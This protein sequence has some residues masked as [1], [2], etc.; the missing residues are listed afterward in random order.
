MEG[1]PGLAEVLSG[2][3]DLDT[4]LRTSGLPNLM[5]L[6][7]GSATLHPSRLLRS[8]ATADLLATLRER[9]AFIVLDLPAVLRSSDAAVLAEMADGVVFVVRAGGTDQ[10]DVEGGLSLLSGAH[11]H[12]VVLNRWRSSMPGFVRRMFES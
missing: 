4:A 7:A 2:A 8:Q 1:S 9:F 12:G 11:L 3:C 5:L 10:G 6:P